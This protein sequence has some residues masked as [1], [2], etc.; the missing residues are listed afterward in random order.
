MA[1]GFAGVGDEDPV[2]AFD[3]GEMRLDLVVHPAGRMGGR[4]LGGLRENGAFKRI[5]RGPEP[6]LA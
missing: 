5:G 1:A 6:R 2:L 4:W 3:A